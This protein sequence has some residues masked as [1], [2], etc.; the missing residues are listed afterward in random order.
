MVVGAGSVE[1][2][3]LTRSNYHDWLLVMQVSLEALGLWDAVESDKVERRDDRLALTTILRGVPSEMKSSLA[4]KKTASE[5]WT[6]IK[7]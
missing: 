2:S 5:A 6:A 7:M 1:L 3:M 4:I